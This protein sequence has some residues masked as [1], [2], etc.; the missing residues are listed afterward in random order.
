MFYIF[1]SIQ[2]LL[3]I[4]MQENTTVIE[5]EFESVSKSG[6]KKNDQNKIERTDR[7]IYKLC[8]FIMGIYMHF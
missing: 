2:I 4:S 3:N 5:L 6:Q 8:Y 7:V 1:E